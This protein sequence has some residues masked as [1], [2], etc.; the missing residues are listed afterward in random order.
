MAKKGEA[1]KTGTLMKSLWILVSGCLSLAGV[2]AAQAQEA[3]LLLNRSDHYELVRT[4][5]GRLEDVLNLGKVAAYG[6][7]REALAVI[8]ADPAT[9]AF[10]LDVLEKASRRVILSHPI[11]ARLQAHLAGVME[12]LVLS[13]RYVYFASIRTNSAHQVTLNSLGGRLDLNQIRLAD[14]AVKS[15]PLPPSCH[16][17]HLV[18]YDGVPLVY[19]WNGYG[20]WKLDEDSMTLQALIQDSD[21]EDIAA[22]ER[23]DCGCKTHPG[24]GPFADDIAM[25]GAGVFRVSRT[26]KL[27]KVLDGRLG[28]ASAPRQSVDLGFD[29]GPDGQFAALSRGV[30]NGRPVIGVLGMRGTETIFQYRDPTSLSIQW[31]VRFP[32]S[33]VS[34]SLG[35]LAIPS[36][37]LFVDK[38]K[39]TIDRATPTGTEIMWNLHELDP[40]AELTSA[41]VILYS[42]GTRAGS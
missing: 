15:F 42:D 4:A 22:A 23:A 17:A 2:G 10:R 16:T 7:S 29:L 30:L 26:G 18:D 9:R 20:V 33:T 36:G 6:Q 11:E 5:S 12:D 3:W 27:Q 8:Y 24:P 14:G 34:P 19:G 25:P 28:A 21:V 40:T 13:S 39:G 31:Q 1:V 32:S 41:R 35:S 38:G 37:I